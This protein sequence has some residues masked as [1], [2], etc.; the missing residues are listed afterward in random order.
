M[1]DIQDLKKKE[2]KKDIKVLKRIP[3][4][5]KLEVQKSVIQMEISSEGLTSWLDHIMITVSRL[6]RNVEEFA[7]WSKK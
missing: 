5:T 7:W 4:E 1:K 3:S 2:K 6:K